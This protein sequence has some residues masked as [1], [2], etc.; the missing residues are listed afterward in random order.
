M[1]SR[2]NLAIGTFRI[3]FVSAGRKTH[4]IV[5]AV[6][7]L[8]WC[9]VAGLSGQHTDI[10]DFVNQVKS[11]AVPLVS[12]DPMT[13]GKDLE[14][15]RDLIGDAPIVL[16]GESQHRMRE[17]YQL[18]HRIIKFLVEEM[19]FNHIAIEDSFYGTIAIDGYIKGADI[20]PVEAL[21]NTGGW[22]LWDTEEMLSF[23]QWL[24]SHNDGVAE[25]RKVSY[26]GIDIQDPWPGIRIL[27]GYFKKYDPEF[28]EIMESRSQVFEVFD[29][30]IWFQIRYAYSKLT[31][32]QKQ[33]VKETLDEAAERLESRQERFVHAGGE[34]AFLDM[35]LVVR[36]LLKS[37]AFFLEL[38][39]AERGDVGLREKSMFANIVRIRE[40]K[41]PEAKIIIWVHN[42]HAAKCPVV[43]LNT[44][45]PE[46]ATLELMGTMLKRKYGDEL[47]S[48]GM[49]SLGVGKRDLDPEEGAAGEPVILDH[50]LSES[51]MDLCFLDFHKLIPGDEEK[52]LLKSPW[53]LTADMGGFLFLV[54]AEAFDGLF[55]IKYTTEVL[56]SS[57]STQRF[58][59]LF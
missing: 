55:F 39:T 34:K 20:S 38:E 8:L 40:S 29:K 52:N 47:K 31:L 7:L 28:S 44:G 54:P 36:H 48:L 51:G 21:R 25:E 23:V 14:A 37:H 12:V 6:F 26:T 10:E 11:Q 42:A 22:Y 57:E 2:T 56:L 32:E 4:G 46:T 41:G 50:V 24:R 16:L 18:K 53:K 30:P 15:L 45:T 49:A 35:V 43:F 3:W 13:E 9:A 59:K 58:K 33:A 5:T 27:S 17:Q 1:N 19:D